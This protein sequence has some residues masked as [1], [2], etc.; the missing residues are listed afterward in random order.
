MGEKE[1]ERGEEET[2]IQEGD[3]QWLG[4]LKGL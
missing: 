1:K 3:L 4:P 2:Q